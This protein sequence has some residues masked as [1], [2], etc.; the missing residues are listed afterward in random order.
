[1][2]EKSVIHVTYECEVQDGRVVVCRA[3]GAVTVPDKLQYFDLLRE[4]RRVARAGAKCLF[5]RRV[6]HVR[7]VDFRLSMDDV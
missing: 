6:V 3:G 2:S 7:V 4:A 1:M 5:G